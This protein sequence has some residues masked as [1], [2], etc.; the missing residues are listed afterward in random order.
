MEQQLELHRAEVSVQVD[1]RVA[2]KVSASNQALTDEALIED[3][4]STLADSMAR[5]DRLK[6]LVKAQ[7]EAWGH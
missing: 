4:K 5:L 2:R 7:L 6:A 1:E 3:R